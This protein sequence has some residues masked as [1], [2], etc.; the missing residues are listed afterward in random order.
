MESG[1]RQLESQRKVIEEYTPAIPIEEEAIRDS[2]AALK[3]RGYRIKTLR[4]DPPSAFDAIED[5]SKQGLLGSR[6]HSHATRGDTAMRILFL[7]ANPFATS[8]L[9]LAQELYGLERELRSV[10]NRDDISLKAHHAVQPEDLIRYVREY[11]PTVVHFS[12]HGSKSGIVLRSDT[13]E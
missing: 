3:V 13:G 6:K 12:G 2:E 9:D 11:S 4:S 10:K 7:A 8:R 5:M 1:K